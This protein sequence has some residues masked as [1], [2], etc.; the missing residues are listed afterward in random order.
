MLTRTFLTQQRPRAPELPEPAA[1][2]GCSSSGLP[3]A[4]SQSPTQSCSTT[5]RPNIL[6]QTSTRQTLTSVT[7]ILLLCVHLALHLSGEFVDHFVPVLL[8]TGHLVQQL[9]EHGVQLLGRRVELQA[10]H[11]ALQ[12]RFIG[13]LQAWRHN[14]KFRT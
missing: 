5:V 2:R 11:F 7:G 8:L 12:S 6:S 14:K 10:A 13:F 4:S 1:S 9:E 3:A